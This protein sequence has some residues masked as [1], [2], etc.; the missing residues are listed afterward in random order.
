MRNKKSITPYNNKHQ[1]HGLWE[2]YYNYKLTYKCFYHNDKQVGYE[3]NY[4]YNGKLQDKIY[5]L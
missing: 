2:L 3:E 4:S 1:R 5:H